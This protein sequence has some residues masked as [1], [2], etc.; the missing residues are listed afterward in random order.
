[1]FGVRTYAG[2][3]AVTPGYG[4]GTGWR[5][6]TAGYGSGTG[7]KKTGR[8]MHPLPSTFLDIIIDFGAL[9]PDS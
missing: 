2:L 4:T 1:M 9:T 6:G 8:A 5:A 7:R 3:G